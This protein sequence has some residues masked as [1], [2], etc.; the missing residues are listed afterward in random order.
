MTHVEYYPISTKLINFLAYFSKIYKFHPIFIKFTFFGL[1]Y[2]LLLL[3][4]LTMMHLCIM[5]F[6]YWMPLL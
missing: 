6:T 3:L 1:I 4:I 5:L 2:A